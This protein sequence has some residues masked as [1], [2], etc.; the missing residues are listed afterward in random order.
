[1]ENKIK[2]ERTQFLKR[3]YN[4]LREMHG[5]YK[6]L[7]SAASI[8]LMKRII[9]Q[10]EME[11]HL[12]EMEIIGKKVADGKLTP[13]EAVKKKAASRKRYRG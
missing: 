3:T 11:I 10:L 4:E 13:K 5:K 7:H 1:M 9:K 8:Q 12:A 2:A 6:N